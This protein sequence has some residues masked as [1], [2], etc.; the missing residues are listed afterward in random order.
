M[1]ATLLGVGNAAMKQSPCSYC[2]GANN[3]QTSFIKSHKGKNQQDKE[4]QEGV[5]LDVPS[6]IR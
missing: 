3:Q 1:P 5:T 6:L 2:R 4:F